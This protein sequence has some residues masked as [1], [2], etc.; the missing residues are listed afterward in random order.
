MIAQKLGLKEGYG[1]MGIILKG[2]IGI[3]EK[4]SDQ[5]TRWLQ[6]MH[7][8]DTIAVVIVLRNVLFRLDTVE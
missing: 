5:F 3:E 7:P 4:D 8:G 6:E 1:R 2:R